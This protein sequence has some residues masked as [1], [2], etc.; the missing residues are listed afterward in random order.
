LID[1]DWQHVAETVVVGSAT[2]GAAWATIKAELRALNERIHRN[3]SDAA[4]AHARIDT[5]LERAKV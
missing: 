3:E 2:A 5:I 4:R 1:I